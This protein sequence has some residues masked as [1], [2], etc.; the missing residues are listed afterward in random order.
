MGIFEK[1]VDWLRKRN[2]LT[3]V[4]MLYDIVAVNLAYFL[5]LWIRF[6]CKFSAIDA[7]YLQSYIRFVGIYTVFC[8]VV[9][10]C[11]FSLSA[12]AS[13]ITSVTLFV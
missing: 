13:I 4:L 8:L 12:K 3:G 5:A 2:L 1:W 10:S 11:V 7:R 9:S 6:D